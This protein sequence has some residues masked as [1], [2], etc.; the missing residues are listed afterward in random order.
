MF[1]AQD[2]DSQVACYPH[3]DLLRRDRADA[4]LG[5]AEFW[6]KS[7]AV[8]PA[9]ASARRLRPTLAGQPATSNLFG[10]TPCRQRRPES[11]ASNVT[12]RAPANRF[13]SG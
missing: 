10:L 5:F 11:Q 1:L 7:M 13:Y 4:V 9:L 6:K 3:A 12:P 2:A 8:F